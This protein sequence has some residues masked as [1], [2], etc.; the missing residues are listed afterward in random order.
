MIQVLRNSPATFGLALMNVAAFGLCYLWIGTLE[1][2]AWWLGLLSFGAQFNPYTLDK[3]PYRLFTHLFLHGDILHL[4][5]NVYGLYA[6]GSSLEL[7]TGTK[8]FLFLYF[9]S[10]L[11]GGLASAYT[12]LFTIGVGASGAI[13]GLFGFSLIVDLSLNKKEGKPLLPIFLN[14][15]VFIIINLALAKSMK[16]DSAA[17]A[18]GLIIGLLMGLFSIRDESF[19]KIRVEF[20][21]LFLLL[22]VYAVLPR[23]QV[24]YYQFFQHLLA[25]ERQESGERLRNLED[26]EYKVL[27]K[28]QLKEWDS[29]RQELNALPFVPEP[30]ARDTFKLRKYIALRKKLNQYRL[31]MLERES[32][33]YVDSIDHAQELTQELFPLEYNLAF[34]QARQ[35]DTI[36]APE[37]LPMTEVWYDEEWKERPSPPGSFYRIGHRDSLGRWQ[38]RVY[39]FY[40]NGKV[41]MKGSYTD[42]KHDGIFL[43]YTKHNTYE[44]AGR[45]ELG[46]R[47]GKWENYHPNGQLQSE[48][49]F[50]DRYFVKNVWDSL[51][52]QLVENGHGVATTYYPT[53]VVK[54][55]GAYRDGYQEGY[56]YGRFENG[57]LYFEENFFQGILERGRS[58]SRTGAEFNYDGSSVY[59]IPASGATAFEKYLN[60]QVL[61]IQADTTGTVQLSFRVTQTG[62]LADFMV[63][64][65][66]TKQ[67]DSVAI[68]IIRQGP[69]WIPAKE[70]GQIPR[71]GFTFVELTFQAQT[72]E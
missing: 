70:H 45:Y 32:Y 10:G 61:Q 11:A 46:R 28:T 30:L 48:V 21:I 43:Y 63:E 19:S 18:G 42:N 37:P 25:A 57:D 8:K 56:W 5:L 35:I 59:P 54:E 66:L 12:G 62:K 68:N 55:E 67:L 6:V 7:I 41:Q 33:V 52:K 1:T 53:G 23:Y 4:L 34:E 31:T 27:F 47:V 71:D 15:F 65:S 14:F 64:R 39:D 40:N 20:A 38:G 2:E 3:E 16:A 9:L 29:V 26:E 44:S 69:A 72:K 58:F 36:A 50:Q 17:H 60:K 13:F 24:Q 49:Y 51:G 22:M